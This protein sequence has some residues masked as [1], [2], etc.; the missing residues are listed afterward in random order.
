MRILFVSP[1]QLYNVANSYEIPFYFGGAVSVLA[2]VLMIPIH[3]LRRSPHTLIVTT[4]TLGAEDR[5]RG[6]VVARPIEQCEMLD[7]DQRKNDGGF[8]DVEASKEPIF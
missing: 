7:T 5:E 3:Y 6:G 1:G 4:T 2:G 8:D